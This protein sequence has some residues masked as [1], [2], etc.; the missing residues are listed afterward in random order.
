MSKQQS[1]SGLPAPGE[2]QGEERFVKSIMYTFYAPLVLYPGWEDSFKDKW[3]EVTAH[4]MKH[5]AEIFEEQV[6][7]ELEAMLYISSATLVAPPSHDWFQIYMWLFHR[8]KPEMAE[9]M[10]LKPDHPELDMNQKEDL[11]RLRSWIFRKQQ[12]HLRQKMK[13][14][15]VLAKPTAEESKVEV[16]QAKMF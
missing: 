13:G 10:D 8:W 14:E 5:Q 6:C 9:Q 12:E 4:R 2:R 11:A 7:T 1:L 16:L 15:K 3:L